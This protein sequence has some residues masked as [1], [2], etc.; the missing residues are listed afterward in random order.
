ML[1][2]I[3]PWEI[4]VAFHHVNNHWAPGF[5]VAWLGFIKLDERTDDVCTESGNLVSKRS[6][7]A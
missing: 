2:E 5:D 1:F 7:R 6:G 4:R 3:F